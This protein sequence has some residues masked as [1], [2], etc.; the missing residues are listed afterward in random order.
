MSKMHV[1]KLT[2]AAD[3][4]LGKCSVLLWA[5]LLLMLGLTV[6]GQSPNTSSLTI[7]VVD[8]NDAA[9][10]G[11][12]ITVRNTATGVTR[13]AISGS[14]GSVTVPALSVGGVY[15]ITVSK[16]GFTAEPVNGLTLR[17]GETAQV[18][19]ALSI[20]G[21]KSEV[22][23]TGTSE[24]VRSDPQIGRLIDSREIEETPILGRKFSTVPLLNSAFRQGKGT[25][26]LFVNQTYFI[27]G[28][29]SRR[30]V[31]YTVDGASNDESWGRQVGV[32]TLPVS[33]V[34][35]VNVMT[36]AFSAEFGWTS[37]PA[38]NI[39]TK[40]GTNAFHG[41]AVGLLRPGGGWQAKRFSLDGFCPAS[42]ALTCTVPTNL[43]QIS[44]ID[45]PDKLGQ[46]AG[47]VGGPIIKDR[48]F[49]F[50]TA[51]RTIQ[52]RTTSLSPTLGSL[53]PSGGKLDY[54]GHYRQSI[55]DGRLDH[56]L[57]SKQSLMFRFNFDQF[58]DDNPQDAVSG[59]TAPTAAR[60]YSRRSWTT[61]LNHT[62]ILS[63]SLLNEFRFGYL[64]GDPV[65]KWESVSPS[66]IY[67]R[68]AGNGALAFTSGQSRVSDL[69]SRQFQFADTLSWTRGP[70][71]LR[72][73]VSVL[74]HRSGGFG[75]EP[76]QLTLGTFTFLTT[77][78]P[79]SNNIR[80]QL[81]LDQ[82]TLADVQNYSQPINFGTTTYDLTQ[83]LVTGF[84]QDKWRVRPNLTLDLGIRYDRQTLTNATKNFEPRLGLAW[85]PAGDS[86]SVIRAGYG[87]YY[88]QVRSNSVAG[89]LI[90]GLDGLASY[91]ANPGQN[92]FPTC[93]T[94]VPV[95]ID[96]RS[97]TLPARDITIVAGKRAFYQAQFARYGIDFSK[98]AA[99]YPDK[100]VNPR[101][102]VVTLGV[103]REI[104]KGLFAG[105][106]YVH[107]H[108][109]NTD[110]TV[111]LNAPTPFARN[112][113]GQTRT[114]ATANATRPI[115]PVNNGVRQINAI[116]NLGYAN[117][118]GLQ[119]QLA[120]RGSRRWFASL[121]YTL[122]KAT[123]TTEPDGNGI[124]PNESNITEL[125]RL[126]N[127]P[128]IVDQ[129]HRAVMQATYNLPL[130]FT[131]GTLIQL[132]SARPFN[133]TTGVDNNGDGIQNDRPVINGAVI[134]KS[135]FLGRGTQDISLYIQNRIRF[136]ERASLTL[137][138]EGFNIFNH[139]NM[140][141]R[142]VT[143][144]GNGATANAD[145]GRLVSVGGLDTAAL[146][147][148]ANIDPPRM[149]QLQAR[150]NF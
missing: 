119:T 8:P 80:N 35:E 123:N 73:G 87:M 82:L 122:S 50:L 130:N 51:E 79:S 77:Y 63:T 78:T 39:V 145:F 49:F 37:G 68:G 47:S 4:Q 99:L 12:A 147:A 55:F 126:E 101:S 134:A 65:T 64:N 117:Y 142:G 58:Y 31:T 17:A 56:N 26:D 116:M 108:L 115:V 32:A 15:Q 86:R 83:W 102:Q 75:N 100:L 53:L 93:F 44:P 105:A 2:V 132:A 90:N 143:V 61:Q 91:T 42:V 7:T 94:C 70:H 54:V 45:I 28:V 3:R 20:G 133:A 125:G 14:E 9:V 129:R 136:N 23:V 1:P 104:V 34:Q 69:Y 95:N 109:S 25:G 98:I 124:G 121:S 71:Y 128:S 118:D 36:N 59:T 40:S 139:A 76:G 16:T 13:D 103:E 140:L 85:N 38:L 146:P 43:K 112:A 88:T 110:R 30:A 57:T 144:Y 72:F 96:P 60:R 135:Y 11:A 106:D 81:P 33:A 113:P 24:G 84:V 141:A 46:F 114:V 148:F 21:A 52:D 111:D 18:K 5:A 131:V 74:R 29:G 67:T 97:L 120:Y 19:I 127:G 138:V 66:T 48:T 149:F 89:Y 10:Q 41:E 27:T 150:F 137:R 6:M 107:Q 22:T 62:A 92:G